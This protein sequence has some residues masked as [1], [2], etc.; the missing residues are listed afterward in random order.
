MRRMTWAARHLATRLVSEPR[1]TNK[2]AALANAAEAHA[3][4]QARRRE[5]EGVE[6]YLHSLRS[7]KA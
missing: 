2:D 3:I 5:Q 1:G 7:Q 4:L 6:S